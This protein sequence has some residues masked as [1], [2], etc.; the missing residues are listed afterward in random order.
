MRAR[1]RLER[2]RAELVQHRDEERRGLPAAG[3][4]HRDDVRA[5]ERD[6]D[7]LALNRG[8]DAVAFPFNRAEHVREEI[9]RLEPAGF[10]LRL[11][12]FSALQPAAGER[13]RA[14]EPEVD[15]V[16]ALAGGSGEDGVLFRFRIRLAGALRWRLRGLRVAAADRRRRSFG[17]FFFAIV[18]RGSDA[19]SS[20]RARRRPLGAGR[21]RYVR[22][23]RADDASAPHPLRGTPDGRARWQCRG[24]GILLDRVSSRFQKFYCTG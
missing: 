16:A 4:R 7:R 3:P 18:R 10:A 13:L 20:R 9:H 19:T 11:E 14:L 12:L 21:E 5:A 17:A 23:R 6:R 8:G 1:A 22:K 15:D 24:R 2:V